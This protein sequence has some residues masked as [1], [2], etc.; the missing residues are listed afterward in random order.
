MQGFDTLPAYLAEI[1]NVPEFVTG[2]M[3]SS[4]IIVS[5]VVT[6]TVFDKGRS[7]GLPQFLVVLPIYFLCVALGWIP[8][9]T[10]LVLVVF[11]AIQFASIISN[12]SSGG[13]S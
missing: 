8:S 13:T 7:N 2:L 10:V 4:L 12:K 5:A 6:V 11:V 1:W 9:W 3:I